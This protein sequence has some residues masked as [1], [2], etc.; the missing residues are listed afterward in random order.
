MHCYGCVALYEASILQ[1]GRFWAA[2]LA[3]QQLHVKR[4]Q[5]TIYVSEP[6][7]A[8]SPGGLLQSSG[9][10]TNSIRF[11]SAIHT[12]YMSKQEKDVFS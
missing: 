7:G 3:F 12:S 6:G 4:G 9:R 11:A 10:G 8:R 1:K 2:S 5:V